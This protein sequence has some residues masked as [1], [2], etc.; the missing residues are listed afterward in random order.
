MINYLIKIIIF[1]T[2]NLIAIELVNLSRFIITPQISGLL[3]ICLSCHYLINSIIILLGGKY[4][5]RFI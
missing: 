4:Y 3:L 2:T 5:E 1:L